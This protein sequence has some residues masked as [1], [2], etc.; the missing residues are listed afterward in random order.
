MATTK[1]KTTSKKTAQKKAKQ[2]V[3][4]APTKK[5]ASKPAEKMSQMAAAIQV[6]KEAKEPLTCKE[7][8][9]RMFEQKLWETSGRTPAATLS[10][11][12]QREIAK[13]GEASRFRKAERG[14]YEL[15]G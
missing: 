6:L 4:K 5:A 7:I 8:V 12:I 2:P 13:K 1:K 14:L 11:A 3:K 10:A 15:A 9:R